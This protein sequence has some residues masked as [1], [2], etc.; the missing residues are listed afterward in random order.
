MINFRFHLVSIIAVFLALAAGIVIGSTFDDDLADALRG[1]VDEVK[2]RADDVD[3]EN[4]AL[5]SDVGRLEDE[6]AA[7]APFSVDSRLTG[8][9]VALVAL[10]GSDENDVDAVLER[11]RE[12]GAEAPAVIWLEDQWQLEGGDEARL[13]E[14]I[15]S[16]LSGSVLRRAA[17]R[18]LADR[19]TAVGSGPEGEPDAL[20]AL[21]DAGFVTIDMSGGF[22][23]SDLESW[24]GPSA[25]AVVVTG[26]DAVEPDDTFEGELVTALD[27]AGASTVL[28]ETYEQHEDGPERGDRI[29]SV[30]DSDDLG[31]RVSTVDSLDRESG[32]VASVLALQELARGVVGHY[33]FGDGADQPLPQWAR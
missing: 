14:A 8:V 6:L 10:R 24:P 32:R 21:A 3:R 25:R 29:R 18:E 26:T 2:Q 11:V 13:Q 28:A 12:A 16:R 9:P 15:G 33:G 27:G 4:D 31:T 23:S 22:D 20:E 1:Q 7:S 19:L 30:R 17:L 5:R